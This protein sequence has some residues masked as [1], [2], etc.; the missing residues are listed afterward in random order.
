MM[1]ANEITS[2]SVRGPAPKAPEPKPAPKPEPAPPKVEEEPKLTP[3]AKREA[4]EA[5]TLEKGLEA[6]K[7]RAEEFRAV[8]AKQVKLQR[9]LDGKDASKLG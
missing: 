5:A 7:N 1:M 2:R 4:R 8:K 3:L 9:G 6:E